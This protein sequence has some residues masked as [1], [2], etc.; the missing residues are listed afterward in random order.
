MNE[1]KKEKSHDRAPDQT[2]I[3]VSIDRV[4]LARLDQA[5]EQSGRTRSNFIRWVLRRTLPQV[6]DL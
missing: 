5:A 1:T 4:M 3:S 2:T 6:A